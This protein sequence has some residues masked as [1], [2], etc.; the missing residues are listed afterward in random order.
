MKKLYLTFE[1]NIQEEFEAERHRAVFFHSDTPDM[2]FQISECPNIDLLIRHVKANFADHDLL[3]V[4]H[5]NP[6]KRVVHVGR[7]GLATVLKL[8]GSKS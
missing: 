5:G 8:Y 1:L 2:V 6:G 7:W 3:L 4:D